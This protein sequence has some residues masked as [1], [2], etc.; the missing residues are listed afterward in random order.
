MYLSLK[1]W[2]CA[3]A[4]I[5]VL[6]VFT[7]MGASSDSCKS[8]DKRLR[9]VEADIK[10]IAR[11]LNVGNQPGTSFTSCRDIY[12]NHKSRGNKAY[13]LQANSGKIP[14]YCHMTSYGIG[15][16]G[17]GGWTLVMK[18]DGHKLAIDRIVPCHTVWSKTL[19]GSQASLQ[20]N[21]N[22]EG[23]NSVGADI[24]HSK[25]RIGILGNQENDWNTCDSRIGFGTGGYP[26]DSNTCGNQATHDPDNGDKHIKAMGYILVQ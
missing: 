11:A 2:V 26:D 17:G 14:V 13:L 12:R 23:F 25:A 3:L 1:A 10:A 20:R 8:F 9:N 19:I 15:A 18:T 5:E 22:K 21:C 6:F 24:P 7:V 16:C 4:L